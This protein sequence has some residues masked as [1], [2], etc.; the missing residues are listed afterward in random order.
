MLHINIQAKRD[1]KQ[2]HKETNKP[3]ESTNRYLGRIYISVCVYILPSGMIS[4]GLT[5]Q[6][7]LSTI[8]KHITAVI[9]CKEEEQGQQFDIKSTRQLSYSLNCNVNTCSNDKRKR[10]LWIKEFPKQPPQEKRKVLQLLWRREKRSSVSQ[11]AF[12]TSEY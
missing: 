1:K 4:M 2:I 9:I 7:T 12:I 5:A 8:C 6:T 3:T 11:A 10:S